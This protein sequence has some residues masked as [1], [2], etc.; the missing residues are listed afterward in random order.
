[1]AH[2]LVQQAAVVKSHNV[3]LVQRDDASQVLSLADNKR[4]DF[5]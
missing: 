4:R 5:R 2:L 3:V 1:M